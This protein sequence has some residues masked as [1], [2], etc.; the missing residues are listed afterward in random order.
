M[1]KTLM[2]SHMA[3]DRLLVYAGSGGVNMDA[4]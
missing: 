2:R 3:G 4:V 1:H